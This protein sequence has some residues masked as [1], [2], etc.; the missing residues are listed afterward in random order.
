MKWDRL[1]IFF[2]IVAVG[3]ALSWG[4]VGQK[5]EQR[6]SQD[7]FVLLRVE[8]G[9][10]LP[11]DSCAAYGSELAL[12]AKAAWLADKR[13]AVYF[14]LVGPEMAMVNQFEAELHVEGRMSQP[15]AVLRRQE[16]WQVILSGPAPLGSGLRIR[17]ETSSGRY[18]AE[19]PL[20]LGSPQ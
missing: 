1:W 14:R 7:Q 3:L 2:V 12:V 11:V 8:S 15:Q 5:T 6:I 16:D 4:K 13:L 20:S 19:Y 9:C 17:F 10:R 18:A